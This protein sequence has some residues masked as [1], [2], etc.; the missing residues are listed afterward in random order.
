MFFKLT[1]IFGIVSL[2]HE[3]ACESGELNNEI[4]NFDLLEQEIECVFNKS[5]QHDMVSNE[6][7][8]HARQFELSGQLKHFSVLE[9]FH[10]TTVK[11]HKNLIRKYAGNNFGNGQ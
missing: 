3:V 2:A 1:L 7:V 6:T 11:V 4:S 10:K 9:F 5:L 8:S